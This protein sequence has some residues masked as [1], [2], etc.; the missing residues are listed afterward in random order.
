MSCCIQPWFTWLLKKLMYLS[1]LVEMQSEEKWCLLL[2]QGAEPQSAG[3]GEEIRHSSRV[4]KG[5]KS[6]SASGQPLHL[7]R[8]SLSF[9]AH[10]VKEHSAHTMKV[11][12]PPFF[13]FFPP[14]ISIPFTAAFLEP[15]T[16]N[17]LGSS[18]AYFPRLLSMSHQK[19]YLH[20]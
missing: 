14:F 9:V 4:T 11:I 7:C 17:M 20:T 2:A 10:K 5:K 1:I 19:K 8:T 15:L 13:F 12:I 16:P 6:C 18:I 3:Q